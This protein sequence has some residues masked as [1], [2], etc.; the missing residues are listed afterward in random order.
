[1]SRCLRRY[2]CE[3]KEGLKD[4]QYFGD[5]LGELGALATSYDLPYSE[6]PTPGVEQAELID[7]VPVSFTKRY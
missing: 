6:K 7:R 4:D 3:G 5:V 1:M 2:S